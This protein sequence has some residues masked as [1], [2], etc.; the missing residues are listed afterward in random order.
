MTSR[1]LY[2]RLISTTLLVT[3]SLY[4][5]LF[6]QWECTDAQDIAPQDK[7]TTDAQDIAPQDKSTI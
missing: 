2:Y 5:V 7:S 6:K 1:V 4:R 3:Y